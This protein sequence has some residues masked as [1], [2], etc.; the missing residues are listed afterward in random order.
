M[1]DDVMV[2]KEIK[3]INK[4]KERRIKIGVKIEVKMGM[5]K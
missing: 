4:T 3:K 2:I 5:K 1:R